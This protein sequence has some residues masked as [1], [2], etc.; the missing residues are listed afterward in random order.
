MNMKRYK[1]FDWGLLLVVF[2][3]FAAGLLLISSAAR[4]NE[5]GNYRKLMVQSAA[6]GLGILVI[7]FSMFFDYNDFRKYRLHFYIGS[8]FLLLLVYVPKLGKVQFGAR[9]WISLGP[10]DFQPLELVKIL[11]I[12]SFAEYLDKKKGRINTPK[13]VFKALCY[14]LPIILLLMAQPDLGGAIVFLCITFGMI[15]IA[16]VNMKI[17]GY[18]CVS[19]ALTLPIL[20]SYVLKPHQKGRIDAFLHPGD[21][22]YEANFHA[23]QSMVAIGSGRLLG[24]GFFNGTQNRY[25]FLPV[26]E[27]DFIF[28]VLGE[29]FG[30]V[31]MM[32]LLV[33]YFIFFLR[34]LNTA[35][36]A[37]DNYGTL[38]CTGVISMFLYQFIQNIGMTIGI[39]PVTGLT[40]PFVSYG[41]SSILTSMMAL[42]M[43][44]NVS[45]NKRRINF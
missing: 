14:P 38:I 32:I 41:G 25:G 43:I 35:M 29:E 7:V 2:L 37:K 31:G 4:V 21:P 9:S 26:N 44:F 17:V 15:F 6:F 12:L 40:L 30:F 22:S 8:I 20:Y 19:A 11:F 27:S 34:I 10:I 28:A 5:T 36:T 24:K 23:I 1:E 3:L 13:E 45:V 16:G 18:F 39:M 42:A 33:F